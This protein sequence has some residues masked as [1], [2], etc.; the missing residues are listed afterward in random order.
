MLSDMLNNYSH[1][2]ALGNL[3]LNAL[4]HFAVYAFLHVAHDVPLQTWVGGD[5]IAQVEVKV[6]FRRAFISCLDSVDDIQKLKG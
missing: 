6:A 2:P 4:F 1:L 5:S 3:L